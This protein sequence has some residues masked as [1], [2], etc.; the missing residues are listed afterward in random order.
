MITKVK[1]ETKSKTLDHINTNSFG[2]FRAYWSLIGQMMDML[3]SIQSEMKWY[4]Y[5]HLYLIKVPFWALIKP[6][7]QVW[8]IKTHINCS[9]S[10]R[11]H[12][13]ELV[14][15]NISRFEKS[16]IHRFLLIPVL[17]YKTSTP[18]QKDQDMILENLLK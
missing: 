13:N 12:D 5:L 18:S 16:V 8:S 17:F 7:G 15:F 10:A 1:V 6:L 3:P 11:F 14:N 2:G 4:N 9:S